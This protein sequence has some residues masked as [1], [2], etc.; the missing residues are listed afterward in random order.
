MKITRIYA[1]NYKTYRR[2]DLDL[3][4]DEDRPIILIGG[5]NGCGKTTLFDAIYHALYGFDIKNV[6]QFEE[7]FNAGVKLEQGLDNKSIVLEISFSG[8]VLGH[9]TPYKLKRTYQL[10]EN[11][12]RWNVELNMNGN[13]YSYGIATPTAQRTQNEEVVNKIIAANLPSELS[14]Y[15]LFDAMK[16]SELVKEEQISKLI[17]KNIN[18]VMGFNKY[19]QLHEAADALLAE[20][21]AAKLENEKQR[22]EYE[23]LGHKKQGREAELKQLREDYEK[24]LE[25]SNDNRERY[26]Q[27]KQGRNADDMTRDRINKQKE[28]IRQVEKRAA[29]YHDSVDKVAKDLE[30]NV[31]FP[32]LAHR[33]R[34]EVEIIV[35]ERRRLAEEW[36]EEISDEQ[37]TRLTHDIVEYLAESYNELK[38]VKVDDVVRYMQKGRKHGDALTDKHPYLSDANVEVLDK[39]ITDAYVNQFLQLDNEREVLD[40]DISELPRKREQLENYERDLSGLDFNLIA[41]YEDNEKRMIELKGKISEAERDIQK[42]SDDIA[43]F[44]YDI[45]QIP[46]PQYD[47]LCKLP[48]FFNDISAKLLASKRRNIEQ[49]M[50]EQL[51]LNLVVYAGVIGRVDLSSDSNDDVSFKI[52]HQNGNEIYLSQLNAGAKQTVMQVLLKVLYELGDYNP[53]VMIDTVMGVLD[54]ESR[55]VILEHYFPDLAHQTILL[56][57]DTEI[58]TDRDLKKIEAYV[59]KAYTLHRDKEAQCTTITNDYFGITIND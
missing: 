40:M 32:A 56:S 24:A 35:N 43:T 57:T 42:L 18:S 14:N 12:V 54:K 20:K 23:Q 6:R 59:A 39:L 38:A 46:D 7:L 19:Y 53:P 2:L 33:I 29:E 49:M 27:L 15:F 52:Y 28:S 16:T 3:T 5:G 31:L 9:E 13:R 17:M 41:L 1:E 58:T 21:K 51:N 30:L 10:I 25:Y 34:P 8:L 50:K 45:P 55:E 44:D 36:G 26:E 47:M 48:K 37:L 22:Q 4:A 11:K